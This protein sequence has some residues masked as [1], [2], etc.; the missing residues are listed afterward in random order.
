MKARRRS[1]HPVPAAKPERGVADAS[2]GAVRKADGA[3][4]TAGAGGS[5]ADG[6]VPDQVPHA[7]IEVRRAYFREYMRKRK[8]RYDLRPFVRQYLL[9]HPCVDCGEADPIVLEF[10]HRDRTTKR[11]NISRYASSRT[12]KAETLLAEM[13]KCDVRCANCHRRKTVKEQRMAWGCEDPSCTITAP[14]E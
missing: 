5:P 7:D 8:G 14:A 1:R 6:R 3:S 10:D 11:F 9:E 13:E 2:P 4:L 12:M